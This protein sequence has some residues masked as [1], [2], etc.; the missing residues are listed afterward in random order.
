[1][2][3]YGMLYYKSRTCGMHHS[4]LDS[5]QQQRTGYHKRSMNMADTMKKAK[6][7]VAG[8]YFVDEEC[9]GCSACIMMAPANFATAEGSVKE[10]CVKH[11]YVKKQ[12]ES[13]DEE[14]AT[15]SALDIC[16]MK[17]IGKE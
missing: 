16:P 14:A 13:D 17:A 6:E 10:N 7:N 3:R 9:V 2:E 11:A 1:M 5:I 15:A 4:T 8:P 12:P